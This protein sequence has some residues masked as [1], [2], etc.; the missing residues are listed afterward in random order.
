MVKNLLRH[1][2]PILSVVF[3]IKILDLIKY[4][5]LSYVF[6]LLA[7]VHLPLT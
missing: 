1:S 4:Y 6:P 7:G 3:W 5:S 2:G